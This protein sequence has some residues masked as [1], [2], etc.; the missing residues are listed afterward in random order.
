MSA[1]LK[2]PELKLNTLFYELL[3]IKRE[4]GKIRPAWHHAAGVRGDGAVSLPRRAVAV[5]R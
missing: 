1:T 5:P 3:D 4:S 2:A